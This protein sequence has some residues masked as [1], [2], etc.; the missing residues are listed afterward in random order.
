MKIFLGKLNNLNENLWNTVLWKQNNIIGKQ[1]NQSINSH[2]DKY[3]RS[4][5]GIPKVS[6][7]L[8]ST[9]CLLGVWMDVEEANK[10]SKI[11]WEEKLFN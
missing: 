6:E 11:I 4:V 8:T 5:K 3:C 2:I 1:S 9:E 7:S 10:A